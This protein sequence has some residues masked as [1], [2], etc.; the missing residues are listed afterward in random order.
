MLQ[1]WQLSVYSEVA[2]VCPHRVLLVTVEGSECLS[3][4][5]P[6]PSVPCAGVVWEQA[7]LLESVH[8]PHLSHYRCSQFHGKNHSTGWKFPDPHRPYFVRLELVIALEGYR[9]RLFR[10]NVVFR[11]AVYGTDEEISIVA[12]LHFLVRTGYAVEVARARDAQASRSVDGLISSV[13]SLESTM[14]LRRILGSRKGGIDP[15]NMRDQDKA[16]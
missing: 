9:S 5:L 8:H 3:R 15:R 6:H 2:F 7:I 12:G 11:T 10:R 13:Q 1:I 14:S 4:F 16:P